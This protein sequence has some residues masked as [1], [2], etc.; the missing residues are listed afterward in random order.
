MT[1][2]QLREM[3]EALSLLIETN[4]E[5]GV[6][7]PSLPK[8]PYHSAMIHILESAKETHQISYTE[9]TRFERK[10]S[11]RLR[12]TQYWEWKLQK[13]GFDIAYIELT[14]KETQE[15]WRGETMDVDTTSCYISN[16]DKLPKI[17][18]TFL[19]VC[20]HFITYIID[21]NEDEYSQGFLAEATAEIN[22]QLTL[23]TP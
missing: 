22:S 12:N 21:Y 23:A 15:L 16:N 11:N 4:R 20:V 18:K 1:L 10:V 2:E 8:N 14:H 9:L 17:E 19:P 3:D 6:G 7:M 13:E 5:V